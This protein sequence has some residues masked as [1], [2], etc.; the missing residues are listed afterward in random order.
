MGAGTIGDP[1]TFSEMLSNAQAGKT[2]LLK[3]G[4]YTNVSGSFSFSGNQTYPVYIK[5][6]EGAHVIID[7]VDDFVVSG[8]DIIFDGSDGKM[9]IMTDSWTGDR[10]L[11]SQNYDI[12]VLGGRVKFIN[13]LIHDFGNVGLWSPAVGAEMYG[14]LIYNIGRGNGSQG[15]PIYTQNNTGRKLI[16]NNVFSQ[17]FESGF[18]IHHYGSGGAV[19]KGY[20]FD[21]NVIIGGKWLSGSGGAR[22]EDT[23]ITNNY[24]V[25][26]VIAAM[27]IGLLGTVGEAL[28]NDFHILDNTFLSAQLQVKQ[29][30]NF[31]IKRNRFFI[32]STSVLT[33]NQTHDGIEVESN[34]YNIYG[35]TTTNKYQYPVA[36]VYQYLA[37]WR[38]GTGF[39]LLGT[40]N[41]YSGSVPPD[42]VT[43]IPNAIRT[44]RASIV[45]AN[46]SEASDVSVDLS[47]VTGL[48]NGVTY[49]LLNA[50]N[51]EESLEFV[52]NGSPVSVPMEAGDWTVATPIAT[53]G[54]AMTPRTKIFPTY[55]VFYLMKK[56]D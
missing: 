11:T 32:D 44:D 46:W 17:T 37:N 55:G 14:N 28:H 25:N 18:V 53:S 42:F 15:H 13:C 31:E 49:E 5:C 24:L 2:F 1:Y 10:F 38:A 9:E 21:K 48:Q 26:N 29:G 35:N 20:T 8:T 6:A 47:T 19:L 41:L 22:V 33:I 51:P 7:F 54:G 16:R 52:Y 36:G 56:P 3:S 23:I 43:V 4:T 40:E 30:E 45:I 50:Q 27:Q 39:D 12:G 34:E